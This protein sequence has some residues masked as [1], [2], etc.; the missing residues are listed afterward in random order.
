MSTGSCG[1]ATSPNKLLKASSTD[2]SSIWAVNEL[3]L[4]SGA[5]KIPSGH[6]YLPVYYP[7]ALL[8]A[9]KVTTSSQTI[10]II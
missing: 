8:S 2:L 5:N 6:E 9:K 7:T 4:T 10:P 1:L 3:L